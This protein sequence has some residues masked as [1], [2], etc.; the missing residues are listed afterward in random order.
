MRLQQRANRAR[1]LKRPGNQR[2]GGA[3]G[4]PI[5]LRPAL[6]ARGAGGSRLAMKRGFSRHTWRN[7]GP[8]PQARASPPPLDRVPPARHRAI[9]VGLAPQPRTVACLRGF[10]MIPSRAPSI[11]FFFRRKPAAKH[12]ERG[13][14]RP[15]PAGARPSRSL[16]GAFPDS[17]DA[18]K[19]SRLVRVGRELEC[20]LWRPALQR[21]GLNP[22][23]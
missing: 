18:K 8:P 6:P 10:P 16:T 22:R 11:D 7:S 5:A 4:S 21:Q 19:N 20:L 12:S 2:V 1:G 9:A 17:T 23:G 13:S 3:T 14:A 15:R